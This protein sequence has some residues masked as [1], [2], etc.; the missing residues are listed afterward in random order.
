R[1]LGV[2]CAADFRR[3]LRLVMAIDVNIRQPNAGS[4]RVLSFSRSPVRIG[5]NELNDIPLQD[6]FVSEW[7]GIIRFDDRQIA[8]FD[9]GSTNGTVL[10]G[11]RLVKSVPAPLSDSSRL[12]LGLLEM[13]VVLRPEDPAAE[14]RGE[15]AA[16][17]KTLSWGISTPPDGGSVGLPG[18]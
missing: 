3:V 8:Y 10:D 11:K 16:T 2:C 12:K 5:R 15:G 17:S 18:G 14:G 9:L 1:R 7:H 6:P 4:S 13:T